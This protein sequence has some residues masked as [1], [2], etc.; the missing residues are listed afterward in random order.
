MNEIDAMNAL[1]SMSK[2]RKNWKTNVRSKPQKQPISIA[3][4]SFDE[5]LE[6]LRTHMNN[7]IN[8]LEGRNV[9]T[10]YQICEFYQEPHFS[11]EFYGNEILTIP[12]E[13]EYSLLERAAIL[14]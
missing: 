3:N 7:W 1:E 2:T 12:E 4:S 8:V 11:G 13:I 5:Q 9:Q 14:L 10:A 6:N